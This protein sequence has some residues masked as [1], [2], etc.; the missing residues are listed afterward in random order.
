MFCYIQQQGGFLA[1]NRS[2]YENVPQHNDIVLSI[3]IPRFF[4]PLR[5]SRPLVLADLRVEKKS[6]TNLIEKSVWVDSF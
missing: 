3:D 6:L 5:F 4:L 1:I 2:D